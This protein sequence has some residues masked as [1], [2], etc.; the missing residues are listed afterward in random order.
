MSALINH[1]IRYTGTAARPFAQG[2]LA[3][4][5]RVLRRLAASPLDQSVLRAAA[6]PHPATA[7]GLGF[8]PRT[9]ARPLA[10]RHRPRRAPPPRIPLAPRQLTRRLR[11]C[12]VAL[13]DSLPCWQPWTTS[14]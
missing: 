12:D 5:T 11:V 6:P 14:G 13:E 4:F 10:H 9:A 7:A 2:L 3:L 1:P 8:R